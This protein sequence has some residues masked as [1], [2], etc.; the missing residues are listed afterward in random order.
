MFSGVRV[1]FFQGWEFRDCAG[2]CSR[3]E[4]LGVRPLPSKEGTTEKKLPQNSAGYV[5]KFAPHKALKS[6]TCGK[7]TLD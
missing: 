4:A 5:T 3:G 6:I 2:T 1:W 7:L